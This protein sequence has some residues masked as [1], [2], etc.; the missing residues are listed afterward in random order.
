MNESFFK[1][2]ENKTGVSMEEVFALANAIQYANFSDEK[3]EVR[4]IVQK[5][6]KLA[7]EKRYIK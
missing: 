3:Q 4:Q 6:G 7:R 5:V 1:K 2:I